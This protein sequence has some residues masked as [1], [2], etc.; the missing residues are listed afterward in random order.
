MRLEPGHTESPVAHPCALLALSRPSYYVTPS[1]ESTA[2]G[3]RLSLCL[4]R[5]TARR[6]S[7]RNLVLPI[8]TQGEDKIRRPSRSVPMQL[9]YSTSALGWVT[10]PRAEAVGDR[11]WLQSARRDS[12]Q[13]RLPAQRPSSLSGLTREIAVLR[14][15]WPKKDAFR[16][17]AMFLLAFSLLLAQYGHAL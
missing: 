13:W 17:N 6:S 4:R 11:F 2:M 10:D 14:A 3:A 15:V 8:T 9:G 5:C 1:R 7:S 16:R 12:P